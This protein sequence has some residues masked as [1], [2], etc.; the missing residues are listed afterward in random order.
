MAQYVGDTTLLWGSNYR[1]K[2]WLQPWLGAIVPI[3][4]GDGCPSWRCYWSLVRAMAALTRA[5][6]SYG[7]A[8]ARTQRKRCSTSSPP[9]VCLCV[10]VF[11]AGGGG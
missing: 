2:L 10:C 5:T 8:T 1:G 7:R 9:S 6:G 4:G 3:A 11:G